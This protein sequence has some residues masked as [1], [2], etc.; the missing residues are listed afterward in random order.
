VQGSLAG[1]DTVLVIYDQNG[2]LSRAGDGIGAA[3][4]GNIISFNLNFNPVTV[5]FDPFSQ[6]LANGSTNLNSVLDVNMLDFVLQQQPA[7][8]QLKLSLTDGNGELRRVTL[9]RSRDAVSYT[10]AGVMQEEPNT[11]LVKYFS[12]TDHTPYLPVTFYRVRVT[13]VS[14]EK[15]SKV[16]RAGKDLLSGAMLFPNP[17][18]KEVYVKWDAAAGQSSV[19]SIIGMDGKAIQRHTTTAGYILLPLDDL[20]AGT[21]VVLVKQAEK[22]IL[23]RQLVVRK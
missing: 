2:Q 14:G 20:P 21:Y 3:V 22:T 15:Y 23:N 8:N 11:G 13:E 6:T 7:A 9:Q 16:L 17:A 1:Q 10:D 4:S 19:V 18:G 12:Y 5:T